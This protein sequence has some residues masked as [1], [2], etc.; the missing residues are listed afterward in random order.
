[1]STV[2]RW[3]AAGFTQLHPLLQQLHQQGGKLQGQVDLKF[4]RG[5]AGLI[6]ARLAKQLGI[7][8]Q[9]ARVD[10]Q[11]DIHDSD[12]TLH[13]NRCFA[14][15]AM[16]FSRF[17]PSGSWPNGHWLESTGALKLALAVDVHQGGWYWRPLKAW[18][19][20]V[21][22]PL[23]LLPRT[24]AYKRIEEGRYQFYV[25]FSLPLLGNL[26]S[27]SGALTLGSTTVAS[28]SAPAITVADSP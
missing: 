24:E 17:Q 27:Y 10:F 11:V 7:P 2:E 16:L 25:G 14:D 4:G 19:H 6:G 26:L 15:S 23:W 28:R 18:L 22:L 12:N 3:F 13:W 5:L 8:T 21:R 20:G 1:M 9:Q